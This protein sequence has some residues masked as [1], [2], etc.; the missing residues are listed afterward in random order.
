MLITT[1][2]NEIPRQENA[3]TGDGDASGTDISQ[4]IRFARSAKSTEGLRQQR[5]YI[6][7]SLYL[8]AEPM[9]TATL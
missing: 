3:M 9:Q 6:I 1:N 4:S 7:S 8:K 2:A 5:R